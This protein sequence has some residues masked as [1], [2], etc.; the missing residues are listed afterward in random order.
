MYTEGPRLHLWQHLQLIKARLPR[1]GEDPLLPE[2]SMESP[3]PVGVDGQT[4]QPAAER[5]LQ[6]LNDLFPIGSYVTHVTGLSLECFRLGGLF[7]SF[8]STCKTIPHHSF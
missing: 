7:V 2:T 8:S 5:Q 1:D 6:V 3:L 4:A